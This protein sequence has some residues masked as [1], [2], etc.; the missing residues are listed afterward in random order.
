[1][2]VVILGGLMAEDVFSKPT[3][4]GGEDQSTHASVFGTGAEF[5][6]D[7]NVSSDVDEHDGVVFCVYSL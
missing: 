7:A 4:G 1:M 6:P 3:N 2:W 5:V